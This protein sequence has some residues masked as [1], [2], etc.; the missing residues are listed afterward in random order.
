M[1]ARTAEPLLE[2]AETAGPGQRP[3]YERTVAK[4]ADAMGSAEFERVRAAGQSLAS[5]EAVE[6]AL[7]AG[8]A[9]PT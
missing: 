8:R 7:A 4:L 6:L 3:H 9:L 2:L 5:H 1:D